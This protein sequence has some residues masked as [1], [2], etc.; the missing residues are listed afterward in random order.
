V[1][2]QVAEELELRDVGEQAREVRVGVGGGSV[3]EMTPP[4]PVI[5]TALPIPEDPNSLLIAISAVEALAES[6]N[7]ADAITPFAITFWFIPLAIHE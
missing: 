5:V 6:V 3:T 7:W 4:V 2:V 1:T